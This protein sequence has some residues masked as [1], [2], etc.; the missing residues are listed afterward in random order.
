MTDLTLLLV[1]DEPALLQ[2][3]LKLV[4]E[5]RPQATLLSAT[6]GVEAFKQLQ[7]HPAVDAVL[8]DIHM[9]GMSGLEL[10]DLASHPMSTPSNLQWIFLTAYDQYAI[11]AFAQ[12]AVDYLLKPIVK[13]RL[14]NALDRIDSPA[15]ACAPLPAEF[16][17]KHRQWFKVLRGQILHLVHIDDILA[18]IADDKLTA[19]MTADGVIGHIRLSIKA[20]QTQLDEQIFWQIHRQSLICAN[21]IR[22][23]EKNDLGQWMAVL[24]NQHRLNVSRRFQHL[25]R[26]D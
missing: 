8:T 7:Q 17:P 5:L 16:T 2:H 23:I 10:A 13:D 1:E 9:P 25:F 19:V 24:S 12:H 3:H 6:N 14:A 11:D 26:A 21:H 4:S 20:L 15:T 18:F 22:T